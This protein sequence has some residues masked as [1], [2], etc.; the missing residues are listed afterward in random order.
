MIT[1]LPNGFALDVSL[2][3]PLFLAKIAAALA[4]AGTIN[5]VYM[6]FR[7]NDVR[8]REYYIYGPSSFSFSSL[9]KFNWLYLLVAAGICVQH[10]DL[11]LQQGIG[12]VDV[13]IKNDF[14]ISKLAVPESKVPNLR[15]ESLKDGQIDMAPLCSLINCPSSPEIRIANIQETPL[16]PRAGFIPGKND[17]PAVQISIYGYNETSNLT[18]TS[19]T[20]LFYYFSRLG[21]SGQR[22]TSKISNLFISSDFKWCLGKG[23]ESNFDQ[24][25]ERDSILSLE[26]NGSVFSATL[27][28]QNQE[29]KPKD[30]STLIYLTHSQLISSSP[31]QC[32]AFRDMCIAMLSPQS[33]FDVRQM[34]N[35]V[36]NLTLAF[37]DGQGEG[38][39]ILPQDQ[40]FETIETFFSGYQVENSSI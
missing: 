3:L 20:V 25:L 18:S 12:V 40:Y 2:N 36:A 33:R 28:S 34:L 22:F 31:S 37:G 11:L 21:I 39:I 15:L 13:T 5:L 27:A 9:F 17:V 38:G 29:G 4:F 26:G 23:L 16:K 14:K 10:S 24:N 32:I 30:E 7:K 35:E 8:Y 1:L 19:D 6:G